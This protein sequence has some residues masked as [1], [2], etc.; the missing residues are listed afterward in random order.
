MLSLLSFSYYRT[1]KA[2]EV[3]NTLIQLNTSQSVYK[4]FGC[5]FQIGFISVPFVPF[6]RK[7]RLLNSQNMCESFSIKYL[8][9]RVQPVSQNTGSSLHDVLVKVVLVVGKFKEMFI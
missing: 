1:S 5:V 6:L 8:P 2:S 9:N 3:Y 4:G 7:L